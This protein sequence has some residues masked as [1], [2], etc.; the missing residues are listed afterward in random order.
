[1]S[2][3]RQMLDDIITCIYGEAIFTEQGIT[4]Q[5][6]L[7]DTDSLVIHSSLVQNLEEKGF[8]ANENGKLTDDL[9]KKFLIN[10]YAKITHLCCPSPKLYTLKYIMPDNTHKEKRQIL[11]NPYTYD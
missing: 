4:K 1:M 6:Y 11:Y 2:Y 10:G 3:S 8:I 5:I 9:N 7:G